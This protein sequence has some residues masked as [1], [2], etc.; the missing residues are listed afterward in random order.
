M[1]IIRCVSEIADVHIA[2][3]S[4]E[5]NV[6]FIINTGARALLLNVLMCRCNRRYDIS[7]LTMDD[8][9]LIIGQRV[10]CVNYLRQFDCRFFYRGYRGTAN[11]KMLR[12]LI[13]I[14]FGRH[15]AYNRKIDLVW[16]TARLD[17][18]DIRWNMDETDR[19]SDFTCYRDS[20][21][22]AG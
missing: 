8:S 15:S 14:N 21:N 5:S 22:F 10:T 16:I 20:D 11:G 6:M 3:N 2:N 19:R 17:Q 1:G 9:S 12:H 4:R 13:A 18:R 7:S